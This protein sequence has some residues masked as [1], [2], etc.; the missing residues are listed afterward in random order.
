MR[1]MMT[2]LCMTMAMAMATAGCDGEVEDF[3][4][5]I[6]AYEDL[7][8]EP[9]EAL[10]SPDGHSASSP[11]P[12]ITVVAWSQ[13]SEIRQSAYCT[14]FTVSPTQS[15]RCTCAG[16]EGLGWG[17][18]ADNKCK[19]CPD[20]GGWPCSLEPTAGTEVALEFVGADQVMY[21][22]IDD[23]VV[24]PIDTSAY[25]WVLSCDEPPASC[26][27]TCDPGGEDCTCAEDQLEFAVVRGHWQDGERHITA[28]GGLSI[29]LGDTCEG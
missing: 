2:T 3:G 6:E 23:G 19:M 10:V 27:H 17:G 25:A 16:L 15:N 24:T 26:P 1:H 11:Y 28:K 18:L 20:G 5:P 9:S 29:D 7:D 21:S 4:E 12:V 14:D 13:G 8:A 22:Y